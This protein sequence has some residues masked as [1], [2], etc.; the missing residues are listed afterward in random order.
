MY[1]IF[2]YAWDDSFYL[3]DSIYSGQ[4]EPY[5]TFNEE[6]NAKRYYFGNS[7]IGFAS[8]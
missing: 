1:T 4:T 8:V 7:G 2:I 5:V 6:V 3:V